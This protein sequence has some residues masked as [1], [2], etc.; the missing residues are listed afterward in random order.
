MILNLRYK[1]C[2]LVSAA[3]LLIFTASSCKKNEYVGKDPYADAKPALELKVN[4]TASTP[5]EGEVGSVVSLSGTGFL[6]YK[7]NLS[8]LFNGEKSE[9]IEITDTQVKVKVPQ[10]A[11]T[12]IV[13]FMVGSQLL[14]GPNFRVNGA[15]STDKT[16]A[17]YVGANGRIYSINALP[18]G[19][20]LIVG[21]F[22]D[23]NNV[24]LRAGYSK[25]AIIS[26]LGVL[27]KSFKPGKGVPSGTLFH[28][29]LLNDGKILIGG[30]FN[31]Y[32]N[33]RNKI[34]NIA[35]I[36]LTGVLDSTI[37]TYMDRGGEPKKDT[38]PTF[39]AFFSGG[40]NKMMVQPDGNVIVIGSFK[41][42]MSKTYYPNQK[43]TIITDSVLVNN[44]AR[45]TPNGALD[46]T[47]NF[48]TPLNKANDGFNGSIRDA[49]MQSD[50]KMVAVGNFSTYNG[51]PANKIARINL[52]GSLDNTF[53]TGSGP[54]GQ[55]YSIRPYVNGKFI[56][57]GEFISFNG[58]P[59]AKAAILNPDGSVDESF[60]TGIGA[61]GSINNATRLG[62]G[63]I[64]L[65]GDFQKFNGITRY[66][67]A[68]VEPSG[69]LS[70]NF[71][72]IGGFG[73]VPNIFISPV[74]DVIN[75]DNGEASVLVGGF[76]S[77]N[78][79]QNTRLVKITY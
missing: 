19:R 5:I 20:M 10:W 62:N 73:F 28:S 71:N 72:T 7:E 53:N 59:I 64:L 34:G 4:N 30:Q 75:V 42:Y 15:V 68:I 67:F 45:I 78:L 63:K 52:D 17:S 55:I 69:Q 21:D 37:Y 61:D 57:S 79:I 27:D 56:I 24:G 46:K 3:L 1:I 41:Y 23:Y 2:P 26:P 36:S 44:V 74:N 39:N 58:K 38:V 6:K 47:Y 77:L 60:N 54:S 18:D 76:N 32:N 31:T 29:A 65:T 22:N 16:F 25:L 48:N 66:G 11:S 13:T 8:V 50:G 9:V 12:G 35:K 51:A 43:D 70:P 14:P 40:V 49:Y 33:K